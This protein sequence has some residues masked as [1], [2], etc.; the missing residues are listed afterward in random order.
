MNVMDKEQYNKIIN[1]RLPVCPPGTPSV[2]ILTPDS[3]EWELVSN[4]FYLTIPSKSNTGKSIN[5][6]IQ[7]RRINQ[8]PQS[9]VIREQRI[10]EIRSQH[11]SGTNLAWADIE[12]TKLLWHGT[13]ATKPNKAYDSGSLWNIAFASPKNPFGRGIYFTTCANLESTNAYKSSFETKTLLL[14]EVL[15]GNVFSSTE[16]WEIKLPPPTFDSIV[17]YIPNGNFISFY[18]VVFDNSRA[19]PAYEVEWIEKK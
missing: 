3:R 10:A 18:Y 14:A 8:S 13:G 11:I 1:W 2:V 6:I 19:F 9:W 16:N 12:Y 4:Y 17:G 5:E 7:I 15:V